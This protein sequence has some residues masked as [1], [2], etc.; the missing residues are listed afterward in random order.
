[1]RSAY[2]M[3]K[4]PLLPIYAAMLGASDAFL[5]FI[6]SVSTLTGLALKPFIGVLSDR[7]GRRVWLLAG[8]A[9]FAGMPFVYRFVGT[10]EHLFAIRVAHGMA[11]AIYGPVTLAYVAELSKER[12]AERLGWFSLARNGGYVVGPAAAG[13][14]LLSMSPVSVFTVI[15]LL[16]SAALV[17]VLLLSESRPGVPGRG[18]TLPAQIVA[19][20]KEGARTRAVWLSGGMDASMYVA[21]YAAKAFVP[22]YALSIGVSVAVAGAFFAVQELVHLALN[23]LGGRLGDRLGYVRSLAVGM[24]ILGLALPLLTFARSALLLMIPAVLMGVAQAMVFP[25]TVALVSNRVT[26]DNLGAGMG[27]IGMLKNTGKVAGPVAAG[28]LIT[29]LDFDFTFRL[30]GIAL[31]LASVALLAGTRIA[32]RRA[33]MGRR[34]QTRAKVGG[35]I[36]A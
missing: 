6:V 12:R 17:P 19:A 3:G 8:T 31:V 25:S 27:F 29:W 1:M 26:Q 11:T 21:L 22:I 14:M 4:T 13:W 2:Q 10:P 28:F 35:H 36:E 15:G 30:M 32:H 20:F 5:G 16:S 23:P 9:F 18:R 33:R 34:A 7:W 24:C